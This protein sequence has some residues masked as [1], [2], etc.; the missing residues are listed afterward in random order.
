MASFLIAFS[1][2]NT[3]LS[4]ASFKP[5]YRIDVSRNKDRHFHLGRNADTL[6]DMAIGRHEG[7]IYCVGT[8]DKPAE[9]KLKGLS[10]GFIKV[11][12][13]LAP[14]TVVQLKDSKRTVEVVIETDVRKVTS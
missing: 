13:N 3:A 5:G 2:K 4:T 10:C 14:G 7:R 9:L 1:A 11:K 8:P 12:S 6:V